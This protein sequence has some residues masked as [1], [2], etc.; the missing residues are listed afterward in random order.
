ML[1]C[2][3]VDD[4]PHASDLLRGYV[5]RTPFL[6]FVAA[7]R[8]PV[9]ALAFLQ[10]EKIDL[11]LLDICM[12]ELTG[13]E[14]LKILGHKARVIITSAHAEYAIKGFEHEVVD[15][16]LKPIPFDRFFK[17]AQKAF[18][19]SSDAAAS[20]LEDSNSFI[21]V[22]T[23]TRGKMEKLDTDTICYV[24]GLKNY[25]SIYTPSGRT[26]AL[27]NIK[28]LVRRLPGNRFLRVHK[29]YIVNIKRIS[30]IKSHQVI[31]R[32]FQERKHPIPLGATY[33]DA[34]YKTFEDYVMDR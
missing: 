13:I 8:S 33:R 16:L 9:K 5:E 11:I 12:P 14:F 15:Y 23:E 4:A 34:F 17:A 26:V 10:E 20:R 2:V 3:I 25:V 24:E 31:L 30:T 1:N 22:K 21:L 7:F 18:N 32:D 6:S 27:L 28:D 29:S 19:A